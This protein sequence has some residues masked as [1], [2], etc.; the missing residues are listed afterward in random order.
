[1]GSIGSTVNIPTFLNQSL[2]ELEATPSLSNTYGTSPYRCGWSGYSF[3]RLSNL[4][5]NVSLVPVKFLRAEGK[6][7]KIL[8]PCTM[9][10]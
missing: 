3:S 1:M 7:L 6:I 8:P 9:S 5:L 4:D 10:D 2:R